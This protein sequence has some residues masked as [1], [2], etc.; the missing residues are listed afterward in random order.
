MANTT[1]PCTK[2][3]FVVQTF[4]D[5]SKVKHEGWRAP[6]DSRFVDS[7]SVG[8]V[9]VL[10]ASLLRLNRSPRKGITNVSVER[11]VEQVGVLVLCNVLAQLNPKYR[12]LTGA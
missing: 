3:Y 5:G 1:Q 2:R 12:V 11:T 6:D 4:T 8:A 9:A 10:T 7:A